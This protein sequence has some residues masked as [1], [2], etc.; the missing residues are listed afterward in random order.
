MNWNGSYEFCSITMKF[1]INVMAIHHGWH[2]FLFSW[3]Y[4]WN[5]T[6]M[7]DHHLV[8][9]VAGRG[10]GRGTVVPSRGSCSATA[11]G[12]KWG[13][14]G[15]GRLGFH[16]VTHNITGTLLILLVVFNIMNMVLVGTGISDFCTD[17]VKGSWEAALPSYG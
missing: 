10:Q 15:T 16:I 17:F 9:L 7:V 5:N 2:Y 11:R 4:E 12:G 13:L 8:I 1:S 6:A 3:H 14:V